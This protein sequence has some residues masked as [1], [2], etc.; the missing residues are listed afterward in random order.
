MTAEELFE[1]IFEAG[2][3]ESGLPNSSRLSSRVLLRVALVT[4]LEEASGIEVSD[5]VALL[6]E[7]TEDVRYKELRLRKARRLTGR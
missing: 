1:L 2:F 3:S 4:F 7:I 6:E 5:A